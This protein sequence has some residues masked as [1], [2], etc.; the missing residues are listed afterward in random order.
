MSYQEILSAQHR[1]C[2]ALIIAT[3]QAAH[4]GDWPAACEAARRFVEQT[5][6]HLAFEEQT[7]FPAL[8]AASPMAA[9]PV[10][11]MRLEHAQMRELFDELI[12]ATRRADEPALADCINTLLMLMRQHNAKEENVLYP[13]ADRSL[14]VERVDP[15]EAARDRN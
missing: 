11:V 8:E 14:P 9:G 6:A 12:E 13:L 5:Q 2:D 7:L 10:G 15:V 1:A 4:G 3:E